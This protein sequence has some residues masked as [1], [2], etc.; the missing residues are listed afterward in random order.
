MSE[1]IKIGNIY[2]TDTDQL[3]QVVAIA[4]D[5]DGTVRISYNSKS[6]KI[7]GR[8]FE[9]AHTKAMPPSDENFKNSSGSLLSDNEI[10]EL[11]KSGILKNSELI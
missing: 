11:V 2:K 9:L 5:N 4:T 6:A 3:R 10:Q 7:A 8:D 1:N